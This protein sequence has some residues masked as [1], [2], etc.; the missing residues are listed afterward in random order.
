MVCLVDKTYCSDTQRE[1]AGADTISTETPRE[2]EKGF[3]LIELLVVITI[4]ALLLAILMPSLRK[5]KQLGRDIVCRSNLKQWALIWA[6]YTDENAGKFPHQVPGTNY[7]RGEWIN[8]LRDKWQTE[9]DIVKCPSALKYKDF[10]NGDPHGSYTSTYLMGDTNNSDIKESCSYGMNT[11]AYS[12]KES[13]PG[14]E[15]NF[16]KTITVNSGSSTIPVFMD[17]MWR[18]GS[19]DYTNGDGDMTLPNAPSEINDWPVQTFRGGIRHFALPRHKSGAKAGTNVLFFDL[20]ARP[21]MIKE[22][23]T[24]KWHRNF[25]TGKWKTMRATIWPGTWM[26]QFSEDF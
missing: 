17:S 18:G 22:M 12:K 21:V 11:W 1:P 9:G 14:N 25:D 7:T 6:M 3:T 5:V 8:A 24:L 13:L 10:G 19:P 16:W 20:S 4:I 2:N 26:V 15:K 23:W